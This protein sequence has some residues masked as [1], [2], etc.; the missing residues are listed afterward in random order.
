MLSSASKDTTSAPKSQEV[1]HEIVAHK[2]LAQML[3]KKKH[4]AL[5]DR[6]W[7]MMSDEAKDKCINYPNVN[8]NTR[9]A[10][11]EYIA[12]LSEGVNLS[13][14]DQSAW[15]KIVSFVNSLPI[16]LSE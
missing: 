12:F 2:G 6:V 9:R 1:E 5:L 15:D 14:L 8:G 13:A 16:L 10:A 4:N 11:D 3:G 7:D